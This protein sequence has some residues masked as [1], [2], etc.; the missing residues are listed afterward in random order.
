MAAIRRHPPRIRTAAKL[1]AVAAA[2]L[3]LGG[4]PP[5]P[6][7]YSRSGIFHCYGV[8]A[9]PAAL[10]GEPSVRGANEK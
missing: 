3:L 5:V 9:L 7:S 8:D 4:C 6:K 1:I 2:A 10:D